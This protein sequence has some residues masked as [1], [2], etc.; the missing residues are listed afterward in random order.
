MTPSS[1]QAGPGVDPARCPLCGADNR[2]VMAAQRGGSDAAKPCWCSEV[3][4]APETL[5]RVPAEACG[6][7]CLCSRCALGLAEE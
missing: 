3:R 7:A 5:A 6:K 2:C 1:P 4:I